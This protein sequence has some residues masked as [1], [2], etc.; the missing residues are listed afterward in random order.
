MDM[1]LF[2]RNRSRFPV[3]ELGKYI[4]Q[5]VAWSP[6]GTGII[7]SDEDQIRLDQWLKDSQAYLDHVAARLRAEG[8]RV[9]TEVVLGAPALAIL[10]YT[11]THHVDLIAMET[12]GRSG[13]SRL[14]LGSVAD[15]VV[16]SA[17][18]P[19]LLNH[20]EDAA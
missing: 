17:D 6:D 3:E 2:I 7:A 20:P 19:V 4:G 16:R 1:Q 11:S 9:K 10:D 8:L 5:Y 15:K 14:F 13:F 18:M 12:H